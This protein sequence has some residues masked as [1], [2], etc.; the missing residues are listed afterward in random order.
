MSQGSHT[1]ATGIVIDN[2]DFYTMPDGMTFIF[3]HGMKKAQQSLTP[4]QLATWY[5]DTPQTLREKS[6]Q[7]A[8]AVVDRYNPQDPEWRERYKNFK[9]SYM[10]GGEEITIYRYDAEHD[11]DYFK[12]SLRHE[13][14][15]GVD[16]SNGW[17]SDEAE[18]KD[19]MQKDKDYSGGVA[20]SVS[21]YGKNSNHED[22]AESVKKYTGGTTAFRTAFPNRAKILQKLLGDIE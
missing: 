18:W 2:A 8:I 12:E 6:N 22:F 15:H 11:P 9:H 21:D 17:M 5:Y 4:E 7:K 3:K 10:T 1:T 19:A 14:G 20:D 13:M 16:K